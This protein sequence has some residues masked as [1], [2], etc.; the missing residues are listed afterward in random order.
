MFDRSPTGVNM[1]RG[2]PMSPA[3]R[4]TIRLVTTGR[5]SGAARE[6][7]LYAFEDGD[8]LVVVG[9]RG[10]AARDPA[11]AVNLRAEPTAVVRLG[12]TERHVR[13]REVSGDERLRLWDLVCEAFPLYATY[14]RRTARQ[15]PVFLLEAIDED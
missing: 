3:A 4:R 12:R 7:T 5:Q 1:V 14:Q 8:R 9:S 11:W 15:I 13:A 2:G 10:G 6:A